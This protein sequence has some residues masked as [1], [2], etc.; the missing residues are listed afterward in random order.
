MASASLQAAIFWINF[1]DLPW[2]SYLRAEIGRTPHGRSDRGESLHKSPN[3]QVEIR[4]SCHMMSVLGRAWVLLGVPVVWPHAVLYSNPVANH[5]THIASYSTQVATR[6]LKHSWNSHDQSWKPGLPF[7]GPLQR[8]AHKKSTGCS[9]TQHSTIWSPSE[10]VTVSWKVTKLTTSV[11]FPHAVAQSP[12][13]KHLKHL[14]TRAG[15]NQMHEPRCWNLFFHTSK[16]WPCKS[17][18]RCRL[19]LVL[20]TNKRKIL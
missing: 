2:V 19:E 15:A 5:Q 3:I 7:F 12:A 4:I 18:E 10:H 13:A 9:I 16:V 14:K 17:I 20:L 11:A 6:K 1:E 8:M